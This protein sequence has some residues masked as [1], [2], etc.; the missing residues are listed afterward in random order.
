[1]SHARGFGSDN[2][3]GVLPEVLDAIA[4]A[5]SGHAESYGHDELSR[6][7]EERLAAE[8]GAGARTFFVF[9]G[10]GAN[11]VALRAACRPWEGVVCADTAHLNVDEAGAP[12]RMGGLKLLTV[13]APD[14]KLTPELVASRLVRFGDEHAVQPRVV[15]VAQ[16]TELGTLY[17]PAELQALADQAHEHGLLLHVDGARLTNAAAALG[18]SLGEAARGADAVSLGGTKA[19]LLYGEA[20]VF[21][22]PELA[23]GALYLRKQSMQLA[24]K[25]RFAAAQFDALLEGERWRAAAG[26]ANAMARRL[27]DAVRDSVEITQPV[28][29]NAVFAILE[30]ERAARLREEW[31]FYTWDEATGEVRWMCAWDTTEEDVEAFAAAIRA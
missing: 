19:G 21:T 8:F 23:D 9:N 22:R 15:S 12:E 13:P 1:M 16:T 26:H 14:G 11:V 4:S 2:H 5:N 30:P 20:V 7:V 6:R 28:E 29:A 3:A 31:F 27:A 10:T 24:S 18:C 17:T 25:M